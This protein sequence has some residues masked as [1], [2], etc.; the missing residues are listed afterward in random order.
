MFGRLV[1]I[2]LKVDAA[3]ELVRIN[4]NTIL[5][6]LRAQKGFR[7]ES[8]YIAPCGSKAIAKTTW[9]TKADAESYDR[10]CRS[11]ILMTLASVVEGKPLME[12]FEFAGAAFQKA[13]SKAA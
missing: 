5:P 2:K 11:E 4:K 13:F 12:G 3:D 9:A 7:D 10:L 6:L 8:L 1:T